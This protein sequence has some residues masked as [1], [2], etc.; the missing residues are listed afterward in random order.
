MRT[1]H[2]FSFHVIIII[3]VAIKHIANEASV[4]TGVRRRGLCDTKAGLRKKKGIW[5]LAHQR[6]CRKLTGPS[7]LRHALSSSSPFPLSP[8]CSSPL[9]DLSETSSISLCL[10]L[11]P[12]PLLHLPQS[13]PKTKLPGVTL[14]S[15]LS[16]PLFWNLPSAPVYGSIRAFSCT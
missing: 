4:L 11:S 8:L 12:A 5:R 10:T 9:S 6:H 7:T 2:L 14:S 16:S 13:L 3:K 1:F 15:G